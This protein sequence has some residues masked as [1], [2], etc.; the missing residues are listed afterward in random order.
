MV[1]KVQAWREQISTRIG[2]EEA[3]VLAY[4][5]NIQSDLDNSIAATMDI[6]TKDLS[7]LT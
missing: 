2:S 4:Q 3:L 5:L 1:K 7:L 6:I